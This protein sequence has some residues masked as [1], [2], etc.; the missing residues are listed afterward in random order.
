MSTRSCFSRRAARIPR[1]VF[2]WVLCTAAC[3]A[4]PGPDTG[5][6]AGSIDA[7]A[8]AAPDAGP[9][10]GAGC[11]VETGVECDGDW[12]DRCDPICRPGQCCS[13]VRGEFTC[14]ARA[15]DG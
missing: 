12:S 13:P 5:M 14:V 9:W 8:D 2:A 10:T 7:G 6:D 4:P 3:D 11:N 1:A 15:E